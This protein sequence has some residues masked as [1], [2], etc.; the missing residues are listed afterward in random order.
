MKEIKLFE[1]VRTGEITAKESGIPFE[2][3]FAYNACKING[4][5]LL[6]FHEV[7]WDNSVE[8]ISRVLV[9]NGITEFTISCTFSSLIPILAVFASYG[10]NMNGLVTVN[11]PYTA[12]MSSDFEK[13][14]AIKMS[15]QRA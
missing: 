13:L 11:A 9:E 15:Y 12:F 8:A 10:W 5:E 1:Q 3:F 2:L 6:D 7:I 14:P 4:N